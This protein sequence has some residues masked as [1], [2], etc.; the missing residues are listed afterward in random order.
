LFLLFLVES[1]F[2]EELLHSGQ[3]PGLGHRTTHVASAA[4]PAASTATTT[5]AAHAAFVAAAD[6]RAGDT[7][8]HYCR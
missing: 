1:E 4:A 3:S 2:L 5:H 8:G 6:L 7:G